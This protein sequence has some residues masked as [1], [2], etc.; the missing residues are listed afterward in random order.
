MMTKH[1]WF[2]FLQIFIWGFTG[3]MLTLYFE[4]GWQIGATYGCAIGC[5][6]FAAMSTDTSPLI[7]EHMRRLEP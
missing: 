7:T 5:G 6:I 2:A 4:L 3:A 1:D